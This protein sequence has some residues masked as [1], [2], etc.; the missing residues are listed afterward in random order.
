MVDGEVFGGWAG[1]EVV[2]ATRLR[3]RARAS[4]L[5]G[6]HEAVA[7][8][9]WVGRGFGSPSVWLSAVTG[10]PVGAC[11]RMLHLGDRLDR[12]TLARAAFV[13]GMLSEPALG[14]LADA[15]SDEI[16]GV[17][18]RDEELLVGWAVELPYRDARVVIE[19][20][21]A[22]ADPDRVQRTAQERYDARRLHLSGMLDRM[23]KLD[24]LLDP[25]GA[26]Y[27]GDALRFLSKPADGE[28]RTPS[29]RRADALVEMARFVLQ[30]HETPPGTGRSRPKIVVTA[31]LDDLI[32]RA[33]AIHATATHAAETDSA[34]AAHAAGSDPAAAAHAAE[35][36]SAVAVDP[37]AVSGVG[38]AGGWPGRF[39]GHLGATVL[40]ADAV[41]RLA[42]DAGVHRLVTAGGSC[43]MD[44]GR[45][46]RS[47]SD[48]VF[49]VLA[50][51]DGGCRFFGCEVPASF[52][53]AHHA[54]H[55]ADLGET[56]PDNLVLLCWHHHHVVHEQHWSLEALGA[57]HFQLL[58][59]TGHEAPMSPPR[60]A[61]T[62]AH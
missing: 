20:W 57:G 14:L 22:H 46:T 48:A 6:V 40:T 32:E 8:G 59:L 51:R 56:E 36:D 61:L 1:E 4:E 10:E 30:H 50:V 34:A 24:G 19:T 33:A 55:W 17:F 43:V 39:G 2:E 21:A 3:R 47:V 29:Q 9:V 13:D 15:W 11:R 26:R 60:L 41:R 37:G 62:H 44:Y 35:T 49:A 18:A 52:C 23:S 16:G 38:L 45:Q 25:E 53:D 28:T 7:A 58:T 31:D 27:V 54:R 12:M 5:I 42:C